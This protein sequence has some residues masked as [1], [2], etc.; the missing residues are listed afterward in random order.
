MSKTRKILSVVLAL[1]MVFSLATVAFAVD[2]EKTEEYTQTWTLGTPVANG[3]NWDIPVTLTTNYATGAIQFDLAYDGVTFVSAKKGS[4][5]Y[6]EADFQPATDGSRVVIVPDT[7]SLEDSTATTINGTIATITVSGT[8]GSVT[9][10]DN[11]KTATNTAGTLIAVRVDDGDLI[12]GNLVA[13]QKV[14]ATNNVATI[15]GAPAGDPELVAKEGMGGV[16]DTTRTA[17]KAT[18]DFYQDDYCTA[19]EDVVD[20][21]VYGITPYDSD[22]A[23]YVTDVFEVKGDGYINVVP[24]EMGCDYGTGAIVQVCKNADDSVV[25]QYALV[26]FGD[27]TGDG[28]ITDEDVYVCEM[29]YNWLIETESGQIENEFINFACDIDANEYLDDTDLYYIELDYNWICDDDCGNS[30]G[31]LNQNFVIANYVS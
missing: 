5:V 18:M 9:L 24:N 28:D 17:F 29:N 15:G 2:Y 7:G 10:K 25:A 20:G 3:S 8:S 6:Y 16:I 19:C 13:G 27:L 22:N 14:N 4:A 12:T 21:Y 1:V 30:D 26:V 23:T 11:A 31:Q